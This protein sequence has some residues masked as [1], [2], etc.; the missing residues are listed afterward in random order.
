MTLDGNRFNTSQKL[1]HLRSRLVPWEIAVE[2]IRLPSHGETCAVALRS[3]K[4]AALF[5]DRVWNGI[6][7]E[8][9]HDIGFW[10]HT[11]T[12]DF[13][14]KIS[15]FGN[16]LA[17]HANNDSERRQSDGL[18]AAALRTSFE[19]ESRTVAGIYCGMT[20]SVVEDLRRN[21]ITAVPLFD[22]RMARNA[23]YHAGRHD[24]IVGMLHNVNIATEETLD[25]RQ[26]SEFRHDQ[27]SVM[28]LR[29]FVHWLDAEMVGRPASFIE[30]EITLR[31]EDYERALAKHGIA[32]TLGVLE[33]TLD[34]PALLGGAAATAA[35]S[36]A[37]DPR[38]ALLGGAAILVGRAAVSL[39]RQLLDLEIARSLTNPEVAFV[40]ELRQRGLT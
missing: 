3:P 38:F 10:C 28:K 13:I 22:T 40:A 33:A 34:F 15:Y 29:R 12:E 17:R 24:V 9:P 39:G 1:E 31:L 18:I 7:N 36:Y 5:Y 2:R 25:W 37:G 27:I 26:V 11:A 8:M 6:E 23:E 20:R 32:T 21:Q 16:E 19:D 35:L 30:D 14:S 4:T